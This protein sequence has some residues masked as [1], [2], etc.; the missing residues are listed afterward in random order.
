MNL[1]DFPMD[2]QRCPLKFG[3][4]NVVIYVDNLVLFIMILN[5]YFAVGYTKTDVLYRWN[6]D[7][8]VAIA[9]DMKL[10]QFDLVECPSGNITDTIVHSV[11]DNLGNKQLMYICES[12]EISHSIHSE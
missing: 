7:R 3:S 9:E 11:S 1:E 12:P 8:Q 2:I 4:C 6:G 5:N 10:S